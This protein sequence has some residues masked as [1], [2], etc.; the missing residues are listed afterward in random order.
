MPPKC[1]T[2]SYCCPKSTVRKLRTKRKHITGKHVLMPPAGWLTPRTENLVVEVWANL[3]RPELEVERPKDNKI[4]DQTRTSSYIDATAKPRNTKVVS[5]GGEDRSGGRRQSHPHHALTM[6]SHN[7]KRK[8]A[9]PAWGA[10][11]QGYPT[12]A[13]AVNRVVFSHSRLCSCGVAHTQR[14]EIGFEFNLIATG[15]SILRLVANCS[16][17]STHQSCVLCASQKSTEPCR[18]RSWTETESKSVDSQIAGRELQG[19]LQDQ[20]LVAVPIFGYFLA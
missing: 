13:S 10:W 8:P 14:V 18:Q 11:L 2:V 12:A 20:K 9:A 7:K 4:P 1:G 3:F 19:G 15:R 16:S 5:R 6:C 17:R